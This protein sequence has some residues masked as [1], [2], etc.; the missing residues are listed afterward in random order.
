M[1]DLFEA[2]SRLYQLRSLQLKS[3]FS[4]IVKLYKIIRMRVMTFPELASSSLFF[5]KMLLIVIAFSKSQLAFVFRLLAF[6][7]SPKVRK[8]F[9]WI[10]QKSTDLRDSSNS[11]FARNLMFKF[12]EVFKLCRKHL[13][14]PATILLNFPE[15]ASKHSSEVHQHRKNCQ[16]FFIRQFVLGCIKTNFSK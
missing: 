4:G 10:S 15:N 9:F 12:Q 6:L 1:L 16:I 7:I 11:K 13:D 14:M 8:M 2:R 5:C 3:H